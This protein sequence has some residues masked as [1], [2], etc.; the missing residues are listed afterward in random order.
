[1]KRFLQVVK[2]VVVFS[3]FIPTHFNAQANSSR[4]YS[5]D[6][7]S[8]IVKIDGEMKF[9]MSTTTMNQEASI[10]P[11]GSEEELIFIQYRKVY[12]TGNTTVVGQTGVTSSTQSVMY[13]R[14]LFIP[15]N[16]EI[17][18]SNRFLKDVVLFIDDH[19][20]IKGNK[21]DEVAIDK[22]YQKYGDKPFSSMQR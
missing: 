19:Q 21:L 15:L 16:K 20:L 5:Y 1:M 13:V 6:K 14:V 11:L 9:R 4:S 3:V 18:L 17:E 22:L 2:L 7:K 12:L 10:F 8:G